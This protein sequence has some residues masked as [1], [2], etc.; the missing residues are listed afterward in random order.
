[1]V[2]PSPGELLDGPRLPGKTAQ[3]SVA[4]SKGRSTKTLN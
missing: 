4:Y 1:M 3:A 2:S